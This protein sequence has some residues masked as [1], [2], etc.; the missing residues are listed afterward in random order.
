MKTDSGLS[1]YC[2]GNADFPNV[3]EGCW[4]TRAIPIY[5]GAI[6]P[7]NVLLHMFTFSLIHVYAAMFRPREK[8]QTVREVISSV[9]TDGT[10]TYSLSA[11]GQLLTDD[12]ETLALLGLVG[13]L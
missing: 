8:L 4:P 9:L 12:S 7:Y 11:F 1:A 3:W 2:H 5:K 10:L 6:A 13:T